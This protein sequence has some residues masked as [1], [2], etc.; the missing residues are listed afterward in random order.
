MLI[1]DWIK[2][3]QKMDPDT[4]VSCM[5]DNRTPDP[6]AILRDLNEACNLVDLTYTIRD[7][8]EL[9]WNGPQARK[10]GDAAAAARKLL[11]GKP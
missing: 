2:M 7:R 9:G 4:E 6:V 5:V 8:E 11:E 10:W 3:L 1:R